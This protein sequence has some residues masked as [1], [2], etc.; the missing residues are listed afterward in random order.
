MLLHAAQ[1]YAKICKIFFYFLRK[2]SPFT[3][4]FPILRYV[5]SLSCPSENALFEASLLAA[6]NSLP[7]GLTITDAN[8]VITYYNDVQGRIDGLTRDEVIGKHISDVYVPSL[9]RS[10]TLAVLRTRQ[11]IYDM[12]LIY[13][14]NAGRVV[15]STHT[16]LPLF[17][18]DRIIGSVCLIFPLV[19]TDPHPREDGPEARESVQ[20][21]NLI[22]SSPAF[23]ASINA[24][25]AAADSPSSVLIYGETGSGKELLA[26]KLHEHSHRFDKSYVA[27]NC[28]AIPVTLLEGILFGSVKGAFTGAQNSSGL[29]EEAQ[30]GT[31]YLD[32]VD[33]MPMELQ[34]KLLRVIQERRVRRVGAIKEHKVDIKIISSF[35]GDPLKAIRAGRVRADLFYRLGVVIIQ[36]PPLRD[37]LSDLPGLVS[38]F[39]NKHTAILKKK[40]NGLAPEV[41]AKFKNYKWPGNVRE[42]EN[43]IEG[44]LNMIREGE[45]IGLAHLPQ[46]FRADSLAPA[47]PALAAPPS[48]PMEES[49]SV[50]FRTRS[51]PTGLDGD[52]RDDRP[53]IG[54]RE[55]AEAL[56]RSRGSLTEAANHLGLSRQVLAY[57]MKKYGLSRHDFDV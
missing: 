46:Y 24:A 49:W 37:R 56:T 14:T 55:I 32:E 39:I 1:K 30:G 52:E 42:L 43:V 6:F 28:S 22:G 12:F 23:R 13:E 44:A 53:R 25:L 48:Q 4:Y 15:N 27:I 20:F 38:F 57:R 16:V 19:L 7:H 29:F 54:R 47:E 45:T 33:S 31:I 5:M 2:F 18:G 17:Q 41:M 51:E 36:V 8:G 34:P 11:P 3:H 50:N 21:G 40:T 35:S 9:D 26:R 10:P